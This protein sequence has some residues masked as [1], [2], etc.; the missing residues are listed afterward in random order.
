M[1]SSASSGSP[2]ILRAS[3]VHGHMIQSV[4]FKLRF[5]ISPLT[6][7]NQ[8]LMFRAVSFGSLSFCHNDEGFIGMLHVRYENQSG[9]DSILF[10]K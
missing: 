7:L 1:T 2:T 9:H 10:D 3:V 8:M 6:G 5:S 4:Q